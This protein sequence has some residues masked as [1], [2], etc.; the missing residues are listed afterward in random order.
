VPTG[1]GLLHSTASMRNDEV[2][3][4]EDDTEVSMT[5]ESSGAPRWYRST[6]ETSSAGGCYSG[7][8]WASAR[9]AA[10]QSAVLGNGYES[11]N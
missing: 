9:G 5:R 10:R 6:A 8:L 3:N 7:S 1:A 4:H 2:R 11:A